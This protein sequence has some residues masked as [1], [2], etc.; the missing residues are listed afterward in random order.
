[1]KILFNPFSGNFETVPV[2]IIQQETIVDGA[3]TFEAG[4]LSLDSGDR[5]N[6]QSTVDSGERIIDTLV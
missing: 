4:D 3:I 5:T 1:M 6:D 2:I